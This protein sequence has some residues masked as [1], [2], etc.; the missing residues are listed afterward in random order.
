MSLAL[1]DANQ[2]S[3]NITNK[4]LIESKVKED[5]NKTKVN[6]Q[7]GENYSSSYLFQLLLFYNRIFFLFY[8]IIE[9]ILFVFKLN[10]LT[11]PP[12]AAGIEIS[13]LVLSLFIGEL[14]VFAGNVGNKSESSKFILFYIIL[15]IFTLY[16]FIYFAFIQT[17]CLKLEVIFN[18]LGFSLNIIE[19][20]FSLI[21]FISIKNNEISL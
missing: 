7:P 19:I 6:K 16:S 17:Y 10:I 3:Q 21:A 9:I 8:F 12:T 2:D 11:Y 13:I 1:Q 4:V 14:R 20:I 5:K 18:M 15:T